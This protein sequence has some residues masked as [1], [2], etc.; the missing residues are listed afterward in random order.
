MNYDVFKDMVLVG[1]VLGVISKSGGWYSYHDI[2]KIQ[3]IDKFTN[4]LRKREDLIEKLR[5]EVL[6]V[7]RGTK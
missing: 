6:L 2:E 1:V 7:E 5:E 4:E 3:G